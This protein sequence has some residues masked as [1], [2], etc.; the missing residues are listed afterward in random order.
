MSR[1]S[2]SLKALVDAA[3]LTQYMLA[4]NSGVDRPTLCRILSG[5]RLPSKDNFHSICK[6]LS[7]PAATCDELEALAEM[8]RDGENTYLQRRAIV[9]QLE[10]VS[11]YDNA[12]NRLPVDIV[13]RSVEISYSS[14]S[15][16]VFYCR[17]QFETNDLVRNIIE[18]EYQKEGSTNLSIFCPFEYEYLFS[19]L[20]QLGYS[21]KGK[22]V[23]NHL[24]GMQSFSIASPLENTR[25]FGE[26]LTF[27]LGNCREYYARYFH[28]NRKLTS[29]V[30][31]PFPFYF[32]INEKLILIDSDFTSALLITDKNTV[33]HYSQAFRH[34]YA[35]ATE[36]T[37]R[38]SSPLDIINH[39]NSV[40][41]MNKG[42][43]DAIIIPVPCVCIIFDGERLIGLRR[44]DIP[45]IDKL[46][47]TFRERFN[48]IHASPLRFTQFF[49]VSGL[50]SFVETGVTSELP[51]EFVEPFP[52]DYR[53]EY[54]ERYISTIESGLECYALDSKMLNITQNCCIKFGR[55]KYVDFAFRAN[56]LDE[57]RSAIISE[58]SVISA[59]DDFFDYLPHSRYVLSREETLELFRSRAAILRQR[60]AT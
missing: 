20:Y 28:T 17:N 3:G 25:I 6:A 52:L 30:Y 35:A 11:A 51:T 32:I 39:H 49:T 9:E 42:S 14:I 13:K 29:M 10:R 46:A 48:A 57:P 5:S 33:E 44:K 1:L 60:M 43:M 24:V 7:L 53:L 15:G 34:E 2:T 47:I 18:S 37:T 56:T 16:S 55:G 4:K 36:V 58:E 26:L 21:D 8:D 54:L 38:L 59:F 41:G 45:G 27:S 31:A 40:D 23:I 50:D 19:L 12:A 22:L